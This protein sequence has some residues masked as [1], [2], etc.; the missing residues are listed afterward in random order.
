MQSQPDGNFNI[1][2]NYQDHFSK[3]LGAYILIMAV[4]FKS[5]NQTGGL[6]N[7]ARIGNGK[8]MAKANK[9]QVV[10]RAC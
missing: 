10:P 9:S 7:V 1:I 6:K 3:S 8:N 4:S 2:L 5:G